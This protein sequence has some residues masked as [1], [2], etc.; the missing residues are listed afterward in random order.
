MN[1]SP[2]RTRHRL[3]IL[4]LT[5]LMASACVSHTHVVGL[6]ATGT[7][8]TVARQFYLFFGLFPVNTID[9][10]RMA[11]DLTSYTVETSFGLVDLALSPFLLPFS[12]TTRTVR[13]RT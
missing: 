9:T 1:A 5:A 4:P 12:L 10:Q 2:S 13:V 8:N 6:G 3:A 7:G 11:P